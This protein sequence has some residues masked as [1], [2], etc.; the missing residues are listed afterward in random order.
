MN[1]LRTLNDAV[2]RR[3]SDGETRLSIAQK[4]GCNRSQLS[5]TLNGSVSN[6]TLRTI[7]D[8]LWATSHEPIDFDADAWEDISSN[9]PVRKSVDVHSLYVAPR[10]LFVVSGDVS[11]SPAQ[12]DDKRETYFNAPITKGQNITKRLE[13]MDIS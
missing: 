5:R 4:I 6:L 10:S 3:Q 9:F 8:I 12:Q 1:V 7:S 11:S 13:L 2:G